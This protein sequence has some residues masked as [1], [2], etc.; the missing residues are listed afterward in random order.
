M[1]FRDR[2]HLAL[3]FAFFYVDFKVGVLMCRRVQFCDNFAC[4]LFVE[5]LA[6]LR[7]F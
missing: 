7:F 3:V 2:S 5:A 6:L 1:R 4:G